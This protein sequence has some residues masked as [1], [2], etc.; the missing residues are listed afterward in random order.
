MKSSQWKIREILTWVGKVRVNAWAVV[1][2]RSKDD[3]NISVFCP[4][5][6]IYDLQFANKI[7]STK[8]AA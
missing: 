4:V 6:E 8:P 1:T 5:N 7:R 3:Q 2:T